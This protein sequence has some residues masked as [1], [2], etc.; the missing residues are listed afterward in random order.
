MNVISSSSS[1]SGL[2]TI[3]LCDCEE[4]F[5]NTKREAKFAFRRVDLTSWN[6]SSMSGSGDRETKIDPVNLQHWALVVH[7]ERGKKT[8]VFEAWKDPEN[9]LLQASR[10]VAPDD[11]LFKNAILLGSFDTSPH[12]LLSEAKKVKGIGETYS[13]G[14]L[15]ISNNCQT[16]VIQFL[17]DISPALYRTLR[18]KV[19]A[20]MVCEI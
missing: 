3:P 20:A 14:L 12:H 16:F 4:E 18:Q 8:F 10:A 5:D 11:T 2:Q 15:G 19:P 17:K 1:S 6:S 9:S 7:F 13:L